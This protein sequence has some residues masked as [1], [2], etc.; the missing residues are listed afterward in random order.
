M[1]PQASHPV[2]GALAFS[3]AVQS[4]I[5]VSI[6]HCQTLHPVKPHTLCCCPH[7]NMQ[8]KKKMS[9]ED[10]LKNNRGINDGSDL[11]ADFMRALYDRIVN[12]EIKVRHT[13]TA[14]RCELLRF[15]MLSYN[16][17]HITMFAKATAC[18]G[19]AE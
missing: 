17:H 1:R 3:N 19:H 13:S 12:N 10:F 14:P 4:H 18:C 2:A 15:S 16:G 7:H 11:P 5:P 6:N 8:V 9:P